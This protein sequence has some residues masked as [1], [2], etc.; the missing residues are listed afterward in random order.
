[1]FH[2]TIRGRRDR[3]VVGTDR[4]DIIITEIILKVV[5]NTLTHL[6]VVA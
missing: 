2:I 5:L 1:M 4:H 3:M 6:M